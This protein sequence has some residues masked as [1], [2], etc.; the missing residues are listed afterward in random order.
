VI[1]VSTG[2]QAA[3]RL[4]ELKSI[5]LDY[6]YPGPKSLAL[7]AHVPCTLQRGTVRHN[8]SASLCS[9]EPGHHAGTR[10][11]LRVREL[12]ARTGKSEGIQ[13]CHPFLHRSGSN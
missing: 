6:R 9:T 4:G 12:G 1:Q 5:I 7:H 10:Y 13:T 3:H 2:N 8:R 11:W